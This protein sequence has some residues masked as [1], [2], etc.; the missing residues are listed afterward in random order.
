MVMMTLHSVIAFTGY[1]FCS[2]LSGI[3]CLG[4]LIIMISED[5]RP[6]VDTPTRAR[7]SRQS[8]GT[9]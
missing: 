8:R 6:I 1:V 9:P 4:S 5:L 3:F 2:F 7:D